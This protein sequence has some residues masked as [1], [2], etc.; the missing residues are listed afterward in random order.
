MAY[1]WRTRLHQHT[2]VKPGPTAAHECIQSLRRKWRKQ[3]F[4]WELGNP[5]DQMAPLLPSIRPSGTSLVKNLY[6]VLAFLHSVHLLKSLSKTYLALISKT[7]SLETCSD[8]HLISLCN[9]VYKAISKNLV[10]RLKAI[11]TSLITPF[12]NAFVKGT[13]IQDNVI[14][15]YEFF[16]Y[17]T[18]KKCKKQK[19]CFASLKLDMNKA[20]DRLGWNFLQAVI[21]K[22]EFPRH[23]VSIIKES[24]S[25]VSYQLLLNG[26][27][28]PFFLP[29]R[30]IRQ[31]D[32]VSSYLFILSANVFWWKESLPRS[33]VGSKL[34]EIPVP[35]I[36]SY[37]QMTLCFTSK[38]QTNPSSSLKKNYLGSV[39]SGQ[40]LSKSK[41]EC[42]F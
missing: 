20:Y 16:N 36:P 1:Y 4:K 7:P 21:I 29:N 39:D 31:G 40:V 42:F 23:W 25:I 15:A 24:I 32:P 37:L 38:S 33:A 35:L 2:K 3:F 17:I 28:S 8:F 10:N 11:M 12:G 5:Q 30:G 14:L 34:V 9:V 13:H 41:S 27:L 18:P 19:T 6:T 26:T 22:M